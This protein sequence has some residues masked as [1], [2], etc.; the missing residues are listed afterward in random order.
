MKEGDDIYKVDI[1]HLLW[2]LDK[3]KPL[4]QN[5]TEKE[6]RFQNDWNDLKTNIEEK[7]IP[8]ILRKAKNSK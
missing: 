4:I 8:R 5:S 6:S 7:L 3:K 1:D 2:K